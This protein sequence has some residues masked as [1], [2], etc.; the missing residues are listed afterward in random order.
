M[1]HSDMMRNAR[2]SVG[3][4]FLSAALILKLHLSILVSN[5][6]ISKTHSSCRRGREITS[7]SARAL[8]QVSRS[9]RRVVNFSSF[10]F[11]NVTVAIVSFT[12]TLVPRRFVDRSNCAAFRR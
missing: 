6:S 2:K 10:L 8:T 11:R 3:P 7:N 9:V 1:L 4:L 12:V 5:F